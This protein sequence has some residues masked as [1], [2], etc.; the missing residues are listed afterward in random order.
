MTIFPVADT[1][2]ADTLVVLLTAPGR[3]AVASIRVQGP[4]ATDLVAAGFVPVGRAPLAAAPPGRLLFGHWVADSQCSAS[5]EEV[6]VCRT[7]SDGWEIHCHGGDA[8]A[9]LIIRCLRAA[10][11]VPCDPA[12]WF[13]WQ[14]P[15]PLVAAAHRALL[16]ATTERTAA[17]LLDQSRGALGDC[18]ESLITKLEGGTSSVARSLERLL[19][20]A[21][22]GMHLTSPWQVVIAGPPNVGKS[23]LL[24]RLLGYQRT[25][26]FDAPGTTRDA[27]TATTA[28]DGW[29]VELTDTAG[30]RVPNHPTEAAG[31][32]RSELAMRT[33]DLI[34]LVQDQSVP[35]EAEE[36]RLPAA[37]RVL[38]IANKSDLPP[39]PH[40]VRGDGHLAVSARTGDGI[41][42]LSQALVQRLVQPAPL[43]GEAVPFTAQQVHALRRAHALIRQGQLA[44]A[45][46][47]L[48]SLIVAP[49]S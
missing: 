32:H 11:G 39:H 6:V 10:G 43:P 13:D 16:D 19:R 27:V 45:Q 47:Q 30:L 48:R 33:A 42:Q 22:V 44:L 46:E 37:A 2:V 5:G 18:L 36:P 14:T 25:I 8:A 28:L 40:G 3:G 35:A 34:L 38:R 4:Q 31:V 1:P 26:V 21:H 7:S 15:D 12:T 20:L 23:S 9:A 24:N 49:A 29:P 41:P 17:I